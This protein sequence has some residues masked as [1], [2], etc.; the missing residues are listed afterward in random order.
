M[1]FKIRNVQ[2]EMSKQIPA[3]VY[4][5]GS[6]GGN[7]GSE[8]GTVCHPHESGDLKRVICASRLSSYTIV[9]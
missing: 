2:F 1:M 3:G 7:D 9:I 8:R 4:P 6:G 5:R